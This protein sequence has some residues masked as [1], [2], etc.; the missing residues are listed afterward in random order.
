KQAADIMVKYAKQEGLEFPHIIGPQTA[1]KYHPESK[2]KIE[3]LVTAASAKLPL[4][5]SRV[6]FTT[7]TLT[8]PRMD[9]VE[10]RGMEKEW[11]RADID[12]EWIPNKSASAKT[13]NVI[14]FTMHLDGKPGGDVIKLRSSVDGQEFDALVDDG[15]SIFTKTGGKW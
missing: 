1:H 7:H 5:P 6:H 10:I 2:P 11:E 3:E 4:R 12:A 15:G 9:F 8:Y 13:K 14:E